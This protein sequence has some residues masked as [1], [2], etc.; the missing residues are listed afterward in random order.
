MS[1]AP[2]GRR[3]TSRP[4]LCDWPTTAARRLWLRA[5]TCEIHPDVLESGERPCLCARVEQNHVRKLEDAHR[6]A[7]QSLRRRQSTH[8]GGDDTRALLA[9]SVLSRPGSSE[10][11]ASSKLRV[12]YNMAPMQFNISGTAAIVPGIPNSSA[13]RQSCLSPA[14][15]TPTQRRLQLAWRHARRWRRAACLLAVIGSTLLHVQ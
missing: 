12:A 13:Q 10:V 6:Q 3:Q 1:T 9:F 15:H 8:S 14:Q 5:P 2:A 11:R 7:H 4:D